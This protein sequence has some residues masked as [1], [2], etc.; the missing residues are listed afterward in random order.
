MTEL[1]A[2]NLAGLRR[3]LF[4]RYLVALFAVVFVPLLANGLSEAWFGYRDQ[5]AMLAQRLHV[6]ADAA[7]SK[8]QGFLD[9]IA[10]ALQWTV[11]LPWHEGNAGQH[12]ADVL[13]LMRQIPA[14][15][16]VML[17][18][19]NE[20]ERLRIS[21]VDLNV[22][23]SGIVR[24][25]DAAVIGARAARTWFGPVTWYRGSEPL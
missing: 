18:D 21:R 2:A 11:Q 12:R 3:P 15:L 5:S 20:V 10:N 16:E 7:A 23:D 17:V 14:I 9:N 8:I 25:N 19:G 6:E 24:T 22:V 1:A 4:H 13:R